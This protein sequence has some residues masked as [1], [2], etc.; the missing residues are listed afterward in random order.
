MGAAACC[1]KPNDDGSASAK[2][3]QKPKEPMAS[4]MVTKEPASR[5]LSTTNNTPNTT[6]VSSS[7][8]Q[9]QVPALTKP[10]AAQTAKIQQAIDQTKI[11]AVVEQKDQQQRKR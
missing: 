3:N 10:V 9:N 5:G 4:V 7:K 1:E 6:V 2:Q 8:R 11:A